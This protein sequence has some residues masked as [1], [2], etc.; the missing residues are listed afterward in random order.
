MTVRR[1]SKD[2]GRFNQAFNFDSGINPKKYTQNGGFEKFSNFLKC[3][4][5]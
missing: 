4:F 5:F 3:K 2:I 1:G